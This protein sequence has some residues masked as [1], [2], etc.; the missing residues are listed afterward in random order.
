VNVKV[1]CER[2]EL[3]IYDS[4]DP[5]T[6]CEACREAETMGGA[7]K[8]RSSLK[9][10]QDVSTPSPSSSSSSSSDAP[11]KKAKEASEKSP[12]MISVRIHN[13]Q[14]GASVVAKVDRSTLIRISDFFQTLVENL[15]EGESEISLKEEDVYEA[16]DLLMN[17]VKLHRKKDEGGE[18]A[19]PI[20]VLWN[21]SKAILSEKWLAQEY[22]DAYG[23]MIKNHIED[24]I[25]KKPVDAAAVVEVSGITRWSSEDPATATRV[26]SLGNGIYD[27]IDELS[28]G[29]PIYFRRGL[30]ES[31]H[32]SI[33]EYDLP[34]KTWQIKW[35]ENK[36]TNRAC[37]SVKS[38]PP[39]L[40]HLIKKVW[41]VSDRDAPG[42][43]LK[44]IDQP[45]VKVS[46]VP[47]PPSP[48]VLLFWEMV[49]TV[50]QHVGLMRGP[51][52]TMEDLVKVLSSR[53]DL[54][55]EEEMEEVM[56]KKDLLL[57]LRKFV[58]TQPYQHSPSLVRNGSPQCKTCR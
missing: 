50:F 25:S 15:D 11:S 54:H 46:L 13:E 22:V 21:R 43:G 6:T 44:G 29:L 56:S 19:P 1:N 35:L 39:V 33:M 7:S 55:V 9:G 18:I 37:A 14:T 34:T 10:K 42:A 5:L 58:Q 52:H 36:G 40:P 57:L 8:T 26:P 23:A 4:A 2:R 20:Q 17:L 45:A 28:G 30:T 32:Q 27:R 12:Q 53:K 48:D 41:Q 31:G 16:V 38:N 51:I 47:S 24:M 3:S 49:R